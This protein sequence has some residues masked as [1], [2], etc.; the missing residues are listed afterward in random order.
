MD[1]FEAYRKTTQGIQYILGITGQYSKQTQTITTS[2]ATV[3]HI[4]NIFNLSLTFY[5]ILTDALTDTVT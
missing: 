4:A 2:K 5:D 3:M 1:I